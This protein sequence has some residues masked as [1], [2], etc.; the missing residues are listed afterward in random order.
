MKGE[1]L[2][3]SDLLAD[4]VLQ[5]QLKYYTLMYFALAWIFPFTVI[6]GTF[7]ISAFDCFLLCL[8]RYVI[9][10]HLT[11][12][13][14]STAH[15]FGPQTYSKEQEGRENPLI[16][17]GALGEGYHNYHHTFPFDY[18]TAESGMTFNVTKVFIDVMA[19][20]GQAYDLKSVS[21]S[22][23]DQC[24]MNNQEK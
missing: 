13:I 10:L 1:K 16:S 3:F 6:Y 17:F 11:W 20:I 4:P 21:Q 15:M 24:K 7:N 18:K 9:S 12:F 23:V 5:F 2:D 14:N 8:S 22:V 19:Y